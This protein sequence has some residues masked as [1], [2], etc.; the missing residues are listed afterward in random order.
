MCVCL[1]VCV[2]AFPF[3]KADQ[4]ALLWLT[5]FREPY[6]QTDARTAGLQEPSADHPS[7]VSVLAVYRGS[8]R[9]TRDTKTARSVYKDRVHIYQLGSASA[10]NVHQRPAATTTS[11]FAHTQKHTHTYI[12]NPPPAPSCFYKMFFIHLRCLISPPAELD[13]VRCFCPA[14]VA[15]SGWFASR[16]RGAAARAGGRRS[17]AA[18]GAAGGGGG[19][20]EGGGAA[21]ACGSLR[22]CSPC[23]ESGHTHSVGA[24]LNQVARGGRGGREQGVRESER[25]RDLKAAVWRRF[26]SPY[27][28]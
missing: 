22:W 20:G 16:R 26:K 3:E 21:A 5:C 12:Y 25:A 19:G 9:R 10:Q 11:C 1:C 4:T 24:D 14:P 15:L 23:R 6:T 27:R 28:G 18:G 7:A 8:C 2:R 13:Q 17:A